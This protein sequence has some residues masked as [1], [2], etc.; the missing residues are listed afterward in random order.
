MYCFK[1][2]CAF[3]SVNWEG[4]DS[5]R[6][7]SFSANMLKCA[8]SSVQRLWF[9]DWERLHL[10]LNRVWPPLHFFMLCLTS[11][12]SPPSEHCHLRL[13]HYWSS[14]ILLRAEPALNHSICVSLKV[15][16]REM[17]SWLPSQCLITA[18][19]GWLGRKIN[20]WCQQGKENEADL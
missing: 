18:V 9:S 13:H 3:P 8:L 10:T 15:W 14:F 6:L 17:D 20:K 5:N 19:R 2:I 1:S 16:F 11:P 12:R 7:Y 4:F